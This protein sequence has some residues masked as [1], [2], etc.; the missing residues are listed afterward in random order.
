MKNFALVGRLDPGPLLKRLQDNPGLW[1][2]GER[3]AY[4]GSVHGQASSI[5]LRWVPPEVLER[6][7]A[8]GPQ[9]VLDYA[10]S[11]DT[12]QAKVL[13]PEA[14]EAVLQVLENLGALGGIGHVILTRLPAGASIGKHVDEGLYATVHDRFHACLAA[15]P[16]ARFHCGGETL[17]PA[18]G[19][20]FWFNHK[21]EHWV[22]NQS[23]AERVHLIVDAIAPVYTQRRGVYYQA[24][25]VSLLWEEAEPILREHW[26]EIARYKDI[27][28][29]PDK[30]AYA[31]LEAAG[32]LRCYT[33]RDGYRMVGYAAFIVRRGL[34]YQGSLQAA[35]DVLYVDPGYRAGMTGV[36]LIRYA[37]QR[38]AA[39]GVQVV[40]HHAKRTNKVGQLLERLGY[41]FVEGIYAK[42]LNGKDPTNGI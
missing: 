7:R 28:L 37:E 13:M 34:H 36:K 39:E 4:E 40:Y 42:R 33:V 12:E 30:E 6:A 17:E 32:Q 19:D 24:E 1:R 38:L 10:D 25:R 20:I 2:R 21:L 29:A 41:E 22:E 18:P 35:Q 8:A 16:G 3:E 31:G 5:Q 23:Q 26:E 9:E 27:P 15:A 14:G 11:Q